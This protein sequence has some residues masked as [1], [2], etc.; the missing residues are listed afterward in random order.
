MTIAAFLVVTL[1]SAAVT[2]VARRRRALPPDELAEGP[3]VTEELCIACSDGT[4]AVMIPF[5]TRLPVDVSDTFSTSQDDQRSVELRFVARV[6]TT[7]VR[8]VVTVMCHP[9]QHPGPRGKPRI[10]VM[11]RVDARGAIDV[12]VTESN[13]TRVTHHRGVR[14]GVVTMQPS[15]LSN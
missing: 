2:M 13:Q 10:T 9:I 12:E 4:P 1:I 14:I 6:P 11:V 3:H 8:R 15:A 5:G 7:A